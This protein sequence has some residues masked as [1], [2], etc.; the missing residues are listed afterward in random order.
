MGNA[1]ASKRGTGGGTV[2]TLFSYKDNSHKFSSRALGDWLM[3]Y[4]RV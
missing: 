3:T 2:P 4:G 1:R